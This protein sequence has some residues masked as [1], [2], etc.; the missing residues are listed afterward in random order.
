M[1]Y[2]LV[3]FSLFL[4]FSHLAVGCV[5]GERLSGEAKKQIIEFASRPDI[6]WLLRV[7]FPFSLPLIHFMLM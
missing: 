5:I 7:R 1:Q 3:C 4:D 2:R 6:H